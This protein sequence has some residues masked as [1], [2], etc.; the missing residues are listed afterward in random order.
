MLFLSQLIIRIYLSQSESL[1]AAPKSDT[2]LFKRPKDSVHER[3]I[4]ILP[5]DLSKAFL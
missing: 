2:P 4:R 3:T 5:L 1:F